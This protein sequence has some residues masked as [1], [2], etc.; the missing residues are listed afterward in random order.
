M[1]TRQEMGE[2]GFALPGLSAVVLPR[3]MRESKVLGSQAGACIGPKC[4]HGGLHFSLPAMS[5]QAP[6]AIE[7]P[8]PGQMPS[9]AAALQPAATL[10]SLK[11]QTGPDGSWHNEDSV[12]DQGNPQH[13]PAHHSPAQRQPAVIDMGNISP[14]PARTKSLAAA[15][16]S[17]QEAVASLAQKLTR[18][19]SQT[20]STHGN[21]AAS[22]PVRGKHLLHKLAATKMAVHT[23][24][25][26]GVPLPAVPPPAANTSGKDWSQVEWSHV[27]AGAVNAAKVTSDTAVQAKD[28]VSAAGV[29]VEHRVNPWD[30]PPPQVRINTCKQ[31][32]FR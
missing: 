28:D 20:G 23:S 7:M 26:A 27:Q 10:P 5:W 8:K 16:R 12:F 18:Q 24:I 13:V 2:H 15:T 32:D 30:G 19:M 17:K 4:A 9:T 1:H 21:H 22:L 14:E 29:H 31:I 25:A 11:W 3:A 6:Q